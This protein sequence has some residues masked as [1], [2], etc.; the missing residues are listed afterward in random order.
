[1]LQVISL[2]QADVSKI[3]S[4]NILNL[5][6]N[7]VQRFEHSVNSIFM[8]IQGLFEISS[9]AFLMVYLI[10]W[11]PLFGVAFMI[12]LLLY[13]G[14]MAKVCASLRYRISKVA[15][16]R[17]DIMKS[18]ISGIRTVKMYAWEWPFIERVKRLRTKTCHDNSYFYVFLKFVFLIV[19]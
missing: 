12:L 3:T 13:Y 10:G 5:I 8:L 16:Q 2:N 18:I 17:V 15:D 11:W 9:V 6:A 4:G 14:A 1:M 7:D 19:K